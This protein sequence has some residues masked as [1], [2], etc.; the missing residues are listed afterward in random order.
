MISLEWFKLES[1]NPSLEMT[2]HPVKGVVR[3]TWPIFNF[4]ACNHITG[5]AEA[6]TAK[7]CI[8]VEYIKS[9]PWN[10][11]PPPNGRGQGHM[12]RFLKLCPNHIFGVGETRHFKCRVLIDTEVYYYKMIDY[13]WKRCV[14]L[15]HG[16]NG[17]LIGNLM[18]PIEWHHCQCVWMTFKVTF[19]VWNLSISHT[20][21]NIV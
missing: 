10:Y 17:S 3:V 12:T 15:R 21:W 6:R 13:H 1:S 4:D 11:R 19:A 7:F 8:Q 14:R 5:T 16:C 18:K 20:S 9:E 2:N